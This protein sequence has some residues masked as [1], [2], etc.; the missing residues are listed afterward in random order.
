MP[1]LSFT[2]KPLI[3][4]KKILRY[5]LTKTSSI[6]YQD[7]SYL[8]FKFLKNT[9]IYYYY[10]KKAPRKLTIQLLNFLFLKILKFL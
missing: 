10:F 5:L 1:L 8:Y 9:A 4:L 6:K 7:D 2:W 3:S